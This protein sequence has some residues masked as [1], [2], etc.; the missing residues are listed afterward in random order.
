MNLQPGFSE[1]YKLCQLI[2][3]IPSNT[4]SAERSFS[5]LKRINTCFRCR[6]HQ[7]RLSGLSLIAFEKSIVIKLKNTNSLYDLTI[8]Q[9]LSQKQI[10]LIYKQNRSANLLTYCCVQLVVLLMQAYDFF[11]LDIHSLYHISLK[12]GLS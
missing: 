8:E 12:S 7:E 10:E 4:A 1:V 11:T 9:F 6:Q 2:C 3:T 5:P